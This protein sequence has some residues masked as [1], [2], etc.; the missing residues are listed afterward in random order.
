M[1]FTLDEGYGVRIESGT[2]SLPQRKLELYPLGSPYIITSNICLDARELVMHNGVEFR[3]EPQGGLEFACSD[4][5]KLTA[6]GVTFTSTATS[7]AQGQ[8]LG[9][10]CNSRLS[11]SST[12]DH[13]TIEAGGRRNPNAAGITIDGVKDITI[14]NCNI[15]RNKG[16]GILLLGKASIKN[17]GASGNS[18]AGNEL[19]DIGQKRGKR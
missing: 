8:W 2:I 7:K 11:P 17:Q 1:R 12:F 15:N 16:Y 3:F 19:D 4:A 18:F 10:L 9:L 14:T 13:C 6:T 5:T